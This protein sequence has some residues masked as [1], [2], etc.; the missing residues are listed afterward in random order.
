MSRQ[1][2]TDRKDQQPEL[3]TCKGCGTPDRDE[4]SNAAM[5]ASG[6]IKNRGYCNCK[7]KNRLELKKELKL[8]WGWSC[9]KGGAK[10]QACWFC[11]ARIDRTRIPSQYR[12]I[13]HIR[14]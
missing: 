2:A 6:Y 3:Y 8:W 7:L 10:K 9:D 4:T 11:N 13:T 1:G 12:C 5:C 14:L